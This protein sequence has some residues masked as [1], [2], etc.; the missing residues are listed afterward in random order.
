MIEFIDRVPTYKGKKL[1][2][3]EDGTQETA[4][5]ESA[6]EPIVDGTPIN[7]E[8]MM[9]IQGFNNVEVTQGYNESREKQI[10]VTYKDRNEQLITTIKANGQIITKFIGKQHTITKTTTR[11]KNGNIS[12]VIS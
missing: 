11:S 3:Y 10:I 5:I 4:I 6:D 7:R 8:N 9:A 12:E 1:I 2:T